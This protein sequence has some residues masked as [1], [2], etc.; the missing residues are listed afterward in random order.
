[1][2]GSNQVSRLAS[3]LV[4]ERDH[5][6]VAMQLSRQGLD[7]Q[8]SGIRR[9]RLD[10]VVPGALGA[11]VWRFEAQYF[12][13]PNAHMPFAIERRN[14]RLSVFA[15]AH[16]Q[17]SAMPQSGGNKRLTSDQSA[18]GKQQGRENPRENG[19]GSREA[20]LDEKIGGEIGQCQKKD[21]A[22]YNSDFVPER[23]S[24]AILAIE[25]EGQQ[26]EDPHEAEDLPAGGVQGK[27]I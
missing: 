1:M 12:H 24:A 20:D 11:N 6:D 3:G 25:G 19:D 18:K 2:Q 21:I 13:H 14:R 9:A 27:D 5:D 8:T 16:N 26:K 17:R 4:I 22:P 23:R 7:F 15:I 10:F